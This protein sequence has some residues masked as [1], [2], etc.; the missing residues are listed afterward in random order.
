MSI[1]QYL[2]AGAIA[3]VIT[4][5]LTHE[6]QWIAR[7]LGAVALP[8]GRHIHG[9]PMPRLGGLAIFGGVMAALLLTWPID[10]PIALVREPRYF[11]LAV[12]YAALP[13]PLVGVLLGALALTALGVIDDVRPLAGRAKFPLIYAAASI[14][15]FFGLTTQ[16]ITSPLSGVPIGLGL[17]GDLFTVLWLGSMAIAMNSIDGVDGLAA[18]VAAITGATLLAAGAY[19]GNPAL[20]VLAAAVSGGALGFLRYNFN[21]ARIFMGDSGS[22][23][24]GFLLGVAAVQGLAKTVTALSLA[25]PILALALP[26]L[27]TGY[28]IV[29]RRRNGVSIFL[30]DRGHL[31]HLL[32]DRGLNQRQT[33]FVLYLLSAVLGLGG[34]AVA[35]VNRTVSLVMLAAI[36][37]LL[38][39]AGRRLGLFRWRQVAPDVPDVP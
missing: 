6:M 30:P 39:F 23:L 22:M 12:P 34:L 28:A 19:R 1:P 4:Y 9:Q 36:V 26:I 10:Q 15:V 29:R 32:L 33:V 35:G 16:F 14:P 7:R 31:H 20:M 11:V 21:P 27:D 25:V 5:A 2:V 8:G 18:G 24:F 3:L 17:V 38:V 13:R 37:G